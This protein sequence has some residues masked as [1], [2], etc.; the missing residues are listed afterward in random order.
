M[1]RNSKNI[2]KRKR[3]IKASKIYVGNFWLGDNLEYIFKHCEAS[4]I[5]KGPNP[6]I[7]FHL[8]D[9]SI[10]IPENVFFLPFAPALY[11]HWE[12]VVITF[13]MNFLGREEEKDVDWANIIWKREEGNWNLGQLFPPPHLVTLQR[14]KMRIA[15]STPYIEKNTQCYHR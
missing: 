7:F 13:S 5:L 3:N 14:H 8:F 15:L 2:F 1:A 9:T 12:S 6:T 4:L 10:H 11:S